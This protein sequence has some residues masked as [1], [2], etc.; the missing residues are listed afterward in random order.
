MTDTHGQVAG[1]DLER[2]SAELDE[3]LSDA[4]EALER[5]YPGER[6]GRQPVHTVYVP[7]DAFDRDIFDSYG[8]TGADVRGR[9]RRGLPQA[10][11]RRRGPVRPGAVQAGERADRGPADRLRGRVRRPVRRRGGR[12]GREGRHGCS[13]TPSTKG[14]ASPFHGIRFKSFE[15]PTRERG[16]RTLALF[17]ATLAVDGRLPEGFVVTLPKVT[18]VD[19]VEAMVLAAKRL[20]SSLGAGQAVAPVRAPDR[21]PAVHPRPRRHRP[22]RPDDP[23]RP[24][25]VHRSPLRHLRLLRRP[26]GSPRRS[27]V[28]STRSPTTPRP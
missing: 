16:L 15:R 13:A 2:L 3:R 6:S 8:R 12:H 21:D 17:L 25:P 1:V 11:R 7:A 4:D 14:E 22:G 20:E 9:A 24:R 26:A 10:P 5:H 18:S 27:R 19:Q 28:S 23:R